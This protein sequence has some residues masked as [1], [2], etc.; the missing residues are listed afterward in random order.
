MG[1]GDLSINQEKKLAIHQRKDSYQEEIHLKGEKVETFADTLEEKSSTERQNYISLSRPSLD[2]QPNQYLQSLQQ[3][4]LQ[5]VLS[6]IYPWISPPQNLPGPYDAP[7]YPVP[8]PTI[9][10]EESLQDRTQSTT[11]KTEPPSEDV[12]EE[13]STISYTRRVSPN[14]IPDKESLLEGTVTVSTKGWRRTQWTVTA[15]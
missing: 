2:Q 12:P 4:T 5:P 11:I 10:T 3:E 14:S 8:L 15:G 13:L 6:P 9:K 1:Q 7:Y